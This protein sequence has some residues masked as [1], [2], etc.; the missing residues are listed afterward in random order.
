M[1]HDIGKKDFLLQ[2][3]VKFVNKLSY[4]LC[5]YRRANTVPHSVFYRICSNMHTLKS[6]MC[7]LQYVCKFVNFN[8][9]HMCTATP[10][11]T[12][13]NTIWNNIQVIACLGN[14]G[15]LMHC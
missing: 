1:I 15:D 14:V 2:K 10:Y 8:L 3:Q 5:T 7:C 6:F 4:Y 11:S 13:F 9:V 12:G